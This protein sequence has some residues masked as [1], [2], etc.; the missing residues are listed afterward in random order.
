MKI[1]TQ[2]KLPEEREY[3]STCSYCH[4][5]FEYKEKEAKV[6]HDQRDGSYV[7]VNCPFC[8]RVVT[9]NMNTLNRGH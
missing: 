1:I 4:T 3:T 5:V 8:K 6:T 9:Q 2:G 7:T